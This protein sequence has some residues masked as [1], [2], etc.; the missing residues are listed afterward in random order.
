MLFKLRLSWRS[1]ARRV[2][3]ANAKTETAYLAAEAKCMLILGINEMRGGE[4]KIGV[5]SRRIKAYREVSKCSR[6]S[7]H[8]RCAG[9]AI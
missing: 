5:I 2:A 8:A 9:T 1:A 7:Y 6:L 4:V 3:T